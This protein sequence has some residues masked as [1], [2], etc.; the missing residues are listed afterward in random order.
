MSQVITLTKL[1]C[2][3]IPAEETSHTTEEK[4]AVIKDAEKETKVAET[5]ASVKPEEKKTL[6][7]ESPPSSTTVAAEPEKQAS[8]QPKQFFCRNTETET[9]PLQKA[10]I[11]AD[12]PF[13]PINLILAERNFFGHCFFD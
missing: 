12:T 6:T 1:N 9:R 3:Q 13:R 11:P 7:A 2:W 4:K 10:E 5:V 8:G